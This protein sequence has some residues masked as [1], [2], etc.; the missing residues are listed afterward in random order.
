MPTHLTAPP[1]PTAGPLPTQ[2]MQGAHYCMQ[3]PNQ[4]PGMAPGLIQEECD[5]EGVH[6]KAIA[7]CRAAASVVT[8]EFDYSVYK[9]GEAV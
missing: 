6:V 9:T 4:V 3:N 2:H 5:I 8:Q 7:D 1:L